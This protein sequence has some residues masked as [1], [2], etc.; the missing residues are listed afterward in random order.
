MNFNHLLA[1]FKMISS[2]W[3]NSS[4]WPR[5][6]T[7]TDTN[8]PDQSR[9]GSNNNEGVLD[10]HKSSRTRVSPSAAVK[11]HIYDTRWGS[12]TSLQRCSRRFLQPNQP[13]EDEE[14]REENIIIMIIIIVAIY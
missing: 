10:I 1:Q 14:R 12:L 8:T 6:E 4:V 3:L 11:S 13:T 5:Y 7:E 2:K 9:P